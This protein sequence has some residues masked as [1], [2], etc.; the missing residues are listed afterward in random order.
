M[1]TLMHAD[2]FFFVTTIC[3]VILTVLLIIAWIFFMRILDS[4]HRLVDKA[5]LEGEYLAGEM[6]KLGQSRM[7]DSVVRIGARFI[8]MIISS[9]T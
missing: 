6:H 3:I 5:R 2:I 9:L 7:P 1:N 4:I 8:R